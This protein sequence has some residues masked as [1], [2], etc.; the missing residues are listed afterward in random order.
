MEFPVQPKTGLKI[1]LPQ[2]AKCLATGMHHDTSY[3]PEWWYEVSYSSSP[4]D[5]TVRKTLWPCSLGAGHR[6]KEGWGMGRKPTSAAL[7][8]IQ[9]QAQAHNWVAQAYVLI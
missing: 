9:S 6:N 1:L 8:Y 4:G 7:I 3:S 5:L 2:Q